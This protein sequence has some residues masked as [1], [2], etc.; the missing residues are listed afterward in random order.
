MAIQKTYTKD[1]GTA[2]NYWFLDD[3]HIYRRRKE[4]TFTYYLYMDLTSAQTGKKDMAFSKTFT[5][6]DNMID[7]A[8]NLVNKFTDLMTQWNNIPTLPLIETEALANEPFF[9]GSTQVADF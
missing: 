8:G 4:L 2:G 5:Y 6:R 3:A 1:D 9:A 7:S